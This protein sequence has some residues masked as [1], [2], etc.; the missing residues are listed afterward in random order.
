MLKMFFYKPPWPLRMNNESPLRFN[1]KVSVR[2]LVVAMAFAIAFTAMMVHFAQTPVEPHLTGPLAG[3]IR[4]SAMPRIY[5]GFAAF[6]FIATIYLLF[7]IVKH[8][9]AVNYIELG[10]K[11]ALVQIKSASMSMSQVTIPYQSIKTI[12]VNNIQ[13]HQTVVITSS[14]NDLVLD[15]RCFAT[16]S[17]FTTFLSALEQGRNGCNEAIQQRSPSTTQESDPL[18]FEYKVSAWY[19]ALIV[20]AACAVVVYLVYSAASAD[21]NSIFTSVFGWT[22]NLGLVV[23]LGFKGRHLLSTAIKMSN[24][25]YHIELGPNS[26][27]VPSFSIARSPIEMPYQSIT[28]VQVNN[29]K[30]HKIVVISSSAGQSIL[31][32]RCFST[33]NDFTM[34]LSALE[35]RRN[36]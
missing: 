35:Q 11:G 26:A 10:S 25:S 6:F 4:P 18:R 21:Y 36:G 31:D 15:S 12:Q 19:F 3:T 14:V 17:D 1:Y 9:N 7:V 32:S 33:P 34:F 28:S 24:G 5:W 23:Y 16:P 8:S 2:G 30:K 13:K 29:V 22:V 20:F 27:L